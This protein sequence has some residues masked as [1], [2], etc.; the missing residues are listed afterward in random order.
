MLRVVN[1]LCVVMFVT[2]SMFAQDN[3]AKK[4]EDKQVHER[5]LM[6][7]VKEASGE[8]LPGATV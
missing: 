2:A 7:V 5:T 4:K 6:G 1:L 8:P 3:S